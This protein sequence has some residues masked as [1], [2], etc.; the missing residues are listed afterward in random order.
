M[1]CHHEKDQL[2]WEALVTLPWQP[3]YSYKYAVVSKDQNDLKVGGDEDAMIGVQRQPS[4]PPC[5]QPG[6]LHIA[7]T[8]LL[9]PMHTAQLSGQH[10]PGLV[11]CCAMHSA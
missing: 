9:G 4:I 10:A 7:K 6:M 5:T 3:S 2:I 8:E 1:R 11:S